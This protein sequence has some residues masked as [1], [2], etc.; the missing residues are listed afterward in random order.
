MNQF[1]AAQETII[2]A[3]Q[4]AAEQAKINMQEAYKKATRISLNIDIKAPDIIVPANSK[5]LD[6]ILLDLGHITLTN[7]FND[8]KIK[9]ELGYSAVVDELKMMLQDFKL[10]R[11]KLKTPNE[12]ETERTLLKP[13]TFTLYL[14]RNLTTSWYTAIPDIDVMVRMGELSVRLCF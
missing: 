7:T 12:I 8:M 14:K 3:S 5:S 9:N 2:Q 6:A 10:A 4:A 13:L 11:I 1:Q